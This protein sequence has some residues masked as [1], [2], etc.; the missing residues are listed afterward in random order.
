MPKANKPPASC[1]PPAR[2][3]PSSN[4]APKDSIRPRSRK[5]AK[6][7]KAKPAAPAK[8]KAKPAAKTSKSQLGGRVKPKNLMIFTRQLATLID[9][10]LP[11]LRSLTVLEKQEPNP[12]LARDRRVA[13]RKRAGR[14][15]LLRVARPA[16]E[17]LQ[18]ALCQHGQGRRTRRG[19]RNR[20]QPPRRISGKSPEAEKQDRFRDGL[21]GDR[22]VHRRRHPGVPDD[23]HRAEV[24]GDVRHHGFA[25]CR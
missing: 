23:F 9:S 15:D 4:S 6:A 10:G 8:S 21:S 7:R 20:A 18:Q 24:Q 13:R 17:D 11:L 3:K 5:K 25:S 22:D 14:L 19:A 1:P 12:V 2:P 16:P